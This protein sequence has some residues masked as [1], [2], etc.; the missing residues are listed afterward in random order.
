MLRERGRNERDASR[1]RRATATASMTGER[2]R[3]RPS[4]HDRGRAAHD[5]AR[6]A[7]RGTGADRDEEGLRSRRVR[8]MHRSRRRPPRPVLHDAWRRCRTASGSRPSKGWSAT[9]SSI[10][11]QA[12]FIEH[13]G[14]QCGFCTS[15]PDHVGRC[16]D[17]RGESGLAER[18][19]GGRARPF[20][21][22]GPVEGG[23][24][25]ADERQSL[26]LR[27]L[28][29]HRRCRRRS[30]RRGAEP[31][32]PSRFREPTIRRKRSRPTPGTRSSPSS[33]AAPISSAS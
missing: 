30:R 19:D 18:R 11:L 29:Q 27:L 14:F 10:P 23:D 3:Q 6:C 7:A 15:G 5:A 9:A 22:G 25:R 2:D 28:S 24:P 17:R 26:P 1:R 20:T 32:I 31:C 16:H 12:A 4:S 33:R 8:R 13:D 21:A